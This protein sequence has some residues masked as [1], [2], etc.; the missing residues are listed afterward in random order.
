LI[1]LG[2]LIF[3]LYLY[4]FVGPQDI[5]RV[6]ER[7]DAFDYAF[8]YSLALGAMSLVLLFWAA[9]WH[10]LL[11]DLDVKTRF[12]RTFMYYAVGYFVD[13]VTLIQS[14]GGKVTRLYLVHRDTK[15]R[16]GAIAA[17]TIINRTIAYIVLTVGISAASIY[18]LV[19]S[20]VP[21]F[22]LGLLVLTWLGALISL[23]VLLYLGFGD[24]AVQKLTSVALK[25]MKQCIWRN[26]AKAYPP[27]PWKRYCFSRK[28]L[29]SS[30]LP[31]A[32]S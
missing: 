31:H 26:P 1:V 10:L 8:Y 28:A 24:K 16:Y 13:L 27:E 2:S 25:L 19:R 30:V 15:Q 14:V 12:R 7:I 6:V 5:F 29:S 9:S 22:A 4:F 23:S 21:D 3:I 32:E 18:L 11:F 17:S 20:S